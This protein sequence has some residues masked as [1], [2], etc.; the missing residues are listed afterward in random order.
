MQSDL[1]KKRAYHLNKFSK[2]NEKNYLLLTESTGLSYA[3]LIPITK[4]T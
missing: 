1:Y 4:K 2:S 3:E